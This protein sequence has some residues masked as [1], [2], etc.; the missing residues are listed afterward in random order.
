MSLVGLPSLAQN[1]AGKVSA[2]VSSRKI[3]SPN[4]V[5]IQVPEATVKKEKKKKEV[6]LKLLTQLRTREMS[7]EY[8]KSN[9]AG[10]VF[11]MSVDM[12]LAKKL[13][14]EVVVG[15]FLTSGNNSNFYNEEGKAPSKIYIDIA[16]VHLKPSPS[17]TLSGGLVNTELASM[18]S[19]FYPGGLPGI[20]EKLNFKAGP[21]DVT[22]SANQVAP[23][24]DAQKLRT[25]S[26][27]GAAMTVETISLKI[28]DIK[29][30]SALDLK[31]D[32][33]HFNLSGMNLTSAK[34]NVFYG[35]TVVGSGD[36][37]RFASDFGG[38]EYGTKAQLQLFKGLELM[39]SG[40]RIINTK[41]TAGSNSGYSAS[42][43]PTVTVGN[44]EVKATYTRFYLE[45]DVMPASY[46]NPLNSFT[47]RQGQSAHLKM[48]LIEED[49]TLGA[50]WYQANEIVDTPYQSDRTTYLMTVET[51]YDIL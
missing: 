28:G 7:D 51:T 8:M 5:S 46:T 15:A 47:N 1:Q 45:S 33:S 3:S 40:S 9:Y 27:K 25:E 36:S 23:A 26:A 11:E 17:L 30:G 18:N 35:N 50:N 44:V 31:V 24:V 4:T 34:D 38:Y 32:G 20:A 42:V 13:S 48:K 16:A 12:K 37:A 49:I 22:F 43:G 19:A 21:I 6:G 14:G 39:A 29:E 10:G 41:G 2:K